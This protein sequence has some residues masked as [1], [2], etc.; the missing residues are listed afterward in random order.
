MINFINYYQ[1]GINISNSIDLSITNLTPSFFN[2]AKRNNFIGSFIPFSITIN[3]QY[4]IDNIQL[5]RNNDILHQW[6]SITYPIICDYKYEYNDEIIQYEF[7]YKITYIKNNIEEIYYQILPQL[8]IINIDEKFLY[9]DY[10][11]LVEYCEIYPFNYT[12]INAI[13]KSGIQ[14]PFIISTNI[15]ITSV[16]VDK[17]YNNIL[18]DDNLNIYYNSWDKDK[19][20]VFS[21]QLNDD[22]HFYPGVYKYVFKVNSENIS[23]Q[24]LFTQK[25][26][27]FNVNPHSNTS[28]IINLVSSSD[29]VYGINEDIKI[30]IN[31]T[32]SI[33]FLQCYKKIYNRIDEIWEYKLVEIKSNFNPE[34]I[35]TFTILNPILG[36]H[37][38]FYKFIA[39]DDNG[40]ST[41]LELEFNYIKSRIEVISPNDND[42][43]DFNINN[44]FVCKILSYDPYVYFNFEKFIDGNWIDVNGRYAELYMNNDGYIVLTLNDRNLTNTTELYRYVIYEPNNTSYYVKQ[45]TINYIDTRAM[46]DISNIPTTVEVGKQFT[47]NFYVTDINNDIDTIY[48]GGNANHFYPVGALSEFSDT[49]Y[50]VDKYIYFIQINTKYESIVHNFTIEAK[51][52]D[53]FIYPT[54]SLDDNNILTI[55]IGDSKKGKLIVLATFVK[56]DI[57]NIVNN[58]VINFNNISTDITIDLNSMFTGSQSY[59]FMI[60]FEDQY[61]YETYYNVTNQLIDKNYKNLFDDILITDTTTVFDIPQSYIVGANELEI[62]LNGILLNQNEYIELDSNHVQLLNTPPLNSS[63]L[64]QVTK[65]TGIIFNRIISGD[66]IKNNNEITLAY[67]Y[68]MYFNNLKV[69]LNGT[70]LRR[71]I[72]DDYLET[73]INKITMNYALLPD[74]I[75]TYEITNFNINAF[76]IFREEIIIDVNFNDTITTT[77]PYKMGEYNLKVYVNGLLMR[78]GLD[79]DYIE[80]DNNNF[81]MNYSL[82]AGSIIFYEIISW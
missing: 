51:Y 27:S 18:Q 22:N 12:D 80:L 47:F 5:L 75:L 9:Y 28:P 74:D 52:P 50:R 39:M 58:K 73:D 21:L 34:D 3:S 67:N 14:I 72:N 57:L 38:Q 36:N 30:K 48:L 42:T 10:T 37:I 13:Y 1:N 6:N 61:G 56:D 43:L 2:F 17:Y 24:K 59:T 15:N 53:N 62:F 78:L 71:G 19:Y 70:L 29:L 68:V 7:K 26:I 4:H 49:F 82:P 25:T 33:N 66:I 63:L 32:T 23:S 31:D 16:S 8:N 20:D 40:N 11:D 46:L 76:D 35:Q 69:Y 64:L 77:N 55:S 41:I 60:K 65:G 79:E 81:K 54:L 44:N 45:L